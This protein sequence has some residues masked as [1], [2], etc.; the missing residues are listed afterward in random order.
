MIYCLL[1]G[2]VFDGPMRHMC[3]GSG[4]LLNFSTFFSRLTTSDWH[5]NADWY[6]RRLH[7]IDN[8]KFDVRQAIA[9]PLILWIS[10]RISIFATLNKLFNFICLLAWFLLFI[11][12][13]ISFI[14]Y[15]NNY[16]PIHLLTFSF[17]CQTDGMSTF[18]LTIFVPC[19]ATLV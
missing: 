4:M 18:A 9:Q 12:I 17:Y 6:P 10:W 15:H 3:I 13:L 1:I 8:K 2:A 5:E 16:F 7:S 11:F 14:F 19:N